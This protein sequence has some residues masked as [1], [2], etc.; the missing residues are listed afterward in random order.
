MGAEHKCINCIE[1]GMPL[2]VEN[3]RKTPDSTSAAGQVF[4]YDRQYYFLL[5]YH[6]R[7][8][9]LKS[10]NWIALMPVIAEFLMR[11]S[12]W[13]EA[14]KSCGQCFEQTGNVGA[15]DDDKRTG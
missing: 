3:V 11:S 10:R 5:F 8:A 15:D 1:H 13:R 7:I 6:S 14:V 2:T 4:C 9:G 12:V